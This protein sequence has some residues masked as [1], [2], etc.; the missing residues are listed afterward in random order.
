VLQV[1][2]VFRVCIVTVPSME[3]ARMSRHGRLVRPIAPLP[4]NDWHDS[5]TTLLEGAFLAN[6]AILTGLRGKYPKL[7]PFNLPR[8]ELISSA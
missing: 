4:I 6:P 2:L 5:P 8:M 7:V 1:F 3:A